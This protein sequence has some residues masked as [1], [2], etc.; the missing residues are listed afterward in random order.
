[1]HA[2]FLAVGRSKVKQSLDMSFLFGIIQIHGN[3]KIFS[4]NPILICTFQTS[5]RFILD[6]SCFGFEYHRLCKFL[7]K[8]NF[9]NLGK[10]SLLKN[11]DSNLQRDNLPK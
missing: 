5:H 8:K 11:M 6:F 2:L 4:K 1:M 10:D 7:D 9:A 3:S